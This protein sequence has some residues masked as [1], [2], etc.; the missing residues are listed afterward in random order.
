VSTG[1]FLPT[2]ES[3]VT[4]E[5]SVEF[6]SAAPQSRELSICT[7]TDGEALIRGTAMSL[8]A[9]SP[10]IR[11]STSNFF[12]QNGACLHLSSHEISQT[13]RM[14][15]LFVGELA[16]ECQSSR[17]VDL[18]FSPD[19]GDWAFEL[20]DLGDV[21][22]GRITLGTTV[23]A[24]TWVELGPGTCPG[25]L[26]TYSQVSSLEKCQALCDE[27]ANSCDFV[28]FS[29]SQESCWLISSSCTAA[30]LTAVRQPRSAGAGSTPL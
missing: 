21:L 9:P 11:S 26:A 17:T 6:E 30:D 2:K 16:M 14:T 18:D 27:I 25:A 22:I 7:R 4:V 10:G 15:I 13:W 20:V 5:G 8:L 24:P 28:S 19:S 1:D 12:V 23:D 3:G 29:G